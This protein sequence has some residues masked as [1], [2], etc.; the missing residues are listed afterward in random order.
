MDRAGNVLLSPQQNAINGLS[1]KKEAE[2][3]VFRECIRGPV[4]TTAFM[5]VHVHLL[6]AHVMAPRKNFSNVT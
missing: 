3:V 2:E 5:K 6:V 4:V 1:R